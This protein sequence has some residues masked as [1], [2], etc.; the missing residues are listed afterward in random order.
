MNLTKRNNKYMFYLESILQRLGSSHCLQMGE[1][2][3]LIF[4]DTLYNIILRPV[5]EGSES[6]H[7]WAGNA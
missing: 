6:Y 7:G 1:P 2:H 4:M 5:P 3:I